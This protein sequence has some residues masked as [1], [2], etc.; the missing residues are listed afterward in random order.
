MQ[1]YPFPF[2]SEALV[3][4]LQRVSFKGEALARAIGLKPRQNPCIVDATAGLGRDS[5]VL[6]A[7]GY[8]VIMLERS[9][10]LYAHL[11]Q[12]LESARE[13]LAPIIDRLSLIHTDSINWL[14]SRSADEKP[15]VIYLDPM[16]PSK[17]KS[18]RAKKEMDFLQHLLGDEA[19]AEDENL[20]TTAL[21]C[22]KYRVVVKR[23]RLGCCLNKMSPNFSIHGRSSRFDIYVI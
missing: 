14:K 16:Y 13:Q 4:R 21:S 10:I 2:L 18:A 8:K 15:D 7:L 3:Y 20:L 6:A 9:D 5:L 1:E 11:L 22:A 19:E 12:G 17:R 23:P